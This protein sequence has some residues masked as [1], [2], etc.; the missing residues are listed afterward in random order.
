MYENKYRQYPPPHP[1]THTHAHTT[2]KVSVKRVHVEGL[3]RTKTDIVVEQVKEVLRADSLQQVLYRSVL[4]A[5]RLEQLGVFRHV[6]IKLDTVKDGR[7][8]AEGLE[9][10]FV[11]KELGKVTSSLAANAGTQSGD[12]VSGSCCVMCSSGSLNQ[13]DSTARHCIKAYDNSLTVDKLHPKFIVYCPIKV[14]NFHANS[15][16]FMSIHALSGHFS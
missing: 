9:V 4:S 14:T 2:P 5:Q 16:V 12:A 6:G 3:Q 11:V 7:G 15:N 10:T 13:Y 8:K 1:P